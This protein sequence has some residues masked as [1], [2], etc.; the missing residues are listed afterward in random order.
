MTSSRRLDRDE[1]I[2]LKQSNPKMHHSEI[3]RRV[4][5]STRQV[6][7]ILVQALGRE[8]EPPE[9]IVGEEEEFILYL[10]E[11]GCPY[12]EVARTVDRRASSLGRKYP[13]YGMG[14][15]GRAV[16]HMFNE[17]ERLLE[18]VGRAAA[19]HMAR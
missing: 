2:R 1:I 10:L 7:R 12:T 6:Q 19:G 13:G 5:G 11:D 18:R 15:E 8:V 16:G 17:F 9:P 14:S 3:A 4:G